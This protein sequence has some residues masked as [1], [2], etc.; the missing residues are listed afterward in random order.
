MALGG[1]ESLGQALRDYSDPPGYRDAE[2]RRLDRLNLYHESAYRKVWEAMFNGLQ[3]DLRYP[4]LADSHVANGLGA[5]FAE[6]MADNYPQCP[7]FLALLKTMARD[8]S[9]RGSGTAAKDLQLLKTQAGDDLGRGDNQYAL[10][11]RPPG[12]ERRPAP[13]LC[14]PDYVFPPPSLGYLRSGP[15][16]RD[17]AV[18]SASDWGNHHHYDSL[19][20][21]I[22]SRGT[23]CFPTTLPLGSSPKCR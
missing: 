8:N 23:S 15:E 6:L 10:Y 21:T 3:G 11:Y 16:L 1:I 12:L 7:Q 19:G 17:G 20:L 9:H 13:P 2:G 5:R 18:L 14:L 22:G 4:P